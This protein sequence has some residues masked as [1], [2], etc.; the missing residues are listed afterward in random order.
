MVGVSSSIARLTIENIEGLTQ[1]HGKV[2]KDTK[3]VKYLNIS[4]C[5]EL[6][7]LW[8]SEAEAYE[9]LGGLQKLKVNRCANLISLGEKEMPLKFVREVE[10]DDYRR[11]KS[12]SCPSNIEKLVIRGCHLTT[13]LSFP[14]MD[15]LSS[16]LKFLDIRRCNNMDVS[17]LHNKFLS[18]LESLYIYEM[19][20]LRLF[21][22]GCLSY[23]TKLSIWRCDNIESIPDNGYGFLPFL[24]LRHLEIYNC[25]NLKSFPHEHLQSLTSLEYM[26]IRDCPS[27]DD[28]FPCGLWPPTLK[29]LSVGGLKKDISEWG[30]QNFPASLDKLRLIGRNSDRVVSFGAKAEEEEDKSASSSSFLL[31]SSLTNLHI[32][33]F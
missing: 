24:C 22:E 15:G 1:L 19:P 32:A 25:K 29:E 11:L 31:P 4:K 33:N 16:S 12:Y 23:L 6:A 5:G 30:L 17:W 26:Q 18:S 8:G 27:L 28:S 7:Y 13:S 2:L 3:A 20:K 14:T 21:H 10:I 9:I